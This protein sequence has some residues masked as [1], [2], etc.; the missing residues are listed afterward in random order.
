VK[1]VLSTKELAQA[2]GVS[3]SSIKRWADEG[4]IRVARTVGGHRRIPLPEAI[5]FVRESGMAVAE[6]GILGLLEA[7]SLGPGSGAAEAA[8]RLFDYL[9][10][11]AAAQARGLVQSLFLAGSSVAEIVDGPIREAMHRIGDLWQHRPDGVFCEHR[12]TDIALQA[13]NQ[14][15]LL[16]VEDQKGPVAVGGA[17][18]GDPYLLPSLAATVV[19]VSEGYRT[20]N[21]GPETPLSTLE[22]AADLLHPSLLWMSLSAS[23]LDDRAA[24]GAAR[25]A[26]Q[27]S[28]TEANV[29]VGGRRLAQLRL[30]SAPNLHTGRSMT[31][32]A[33]F[34]RGLKAHT[35]SAPAARRR[36]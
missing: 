27:V 26:A 11:G 31:E 29:I 16:L 34:A 9:E 35:A 20:V 13:M 12:A 4:S 24:S 17:P 10:K 19:L 30:P 33:A 15:R 6:P 14:L 18:A 5:R 2:I 25:L 7:A 22:R 1:E 23:T 28:H 32:L 36:R 3:E 21:L 8:D